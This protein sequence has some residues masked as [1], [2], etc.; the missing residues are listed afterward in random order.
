MGVDVSVDSAAGRGR[1]SRFQNM[2]A[3]VIKFSCI[4]IREMQ[5][6]AVGSVYLMF[7]R[8]LVRLQPPE[9]QTAALELSEIADIIAQVSNS[10]VNSNARRHAT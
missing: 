6:S 2:P 4:I 3:R 8:G 9:R 7:G 1:G 5:R 10:R